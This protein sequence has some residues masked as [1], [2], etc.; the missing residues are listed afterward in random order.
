MFLIAK[1]MEDFILHTAHTKIQVGVVSLTPCSTAPSIWGQNLQYLILRWHRS[2]NIS[3][4]LD[5][6]SLPQAGGPHPG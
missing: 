6:T 1:A 4:G 5:E 3:I 2:F